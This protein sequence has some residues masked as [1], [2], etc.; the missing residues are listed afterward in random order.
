MGGRS[1]QGTHQC[2]RQKHQIHPLGCQRIKSGLLGLRCAHQRRREPEHQALKK[3]HPHRPTPSFWLPPHTGTQARHHQ[4]LTPPGPELVLQKRGKGGRT[5]AHQEPSKPVA[6]LTGPSSNPL[7]NPEETELNWSKRGKTL[8]F[9]I[10]C[11]AFWEAQEDFQVIPWG[12][13]KFTSYL[14]KRFNYIS[15]KQLIHSD[16]FILLN[17]VRPSQPPIILASREDFKASGSAK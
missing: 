1:S 17:E 6:S 2:S 14:D 3:T 9:Y 7:E 11:R 10:F 4:N 12:W 15:F 8:S 5:E 13:L 16:E